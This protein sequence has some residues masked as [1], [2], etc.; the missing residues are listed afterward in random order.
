MAENSKS[1]NDRAQQQT[2]GDVIEGVLC[3]T[4]TAFLPIT[5]IILSIH[6]ETSKSRRITNEK[7]GGG[8]KGAR[9]DDLHKYSC[10]G[11][12]LKLALTTKVTR[13]C[14]GS[15]F[16]SSALFFEN[17]LEFFSL[18]FSIVYHG[19]Y[20]CLDHPFRSRCKGTRRSPH[21]HYP[22]GC[23]LCWSACWTWTFLRE[24]WTFNTQRQGQCQPL[25]GM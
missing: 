23:A 8:K 22:P 10:I 2:N 5:S 3:A 7:G 13:L 9:F 14:S 18:T 16:Q 19:F 21:Q 25:V 4:L 1:N 24:I 11:G 15:K 20:P 12:I 6:V 17:H